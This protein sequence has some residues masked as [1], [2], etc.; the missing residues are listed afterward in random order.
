M[1]S[2]YLRYDGNALV[3]PG[4]MCDE[5]GEIATHLGKKLEGSLDANGYLTSKIIIGSGEQ[6][7]LR[8]HRIIMST[9]D[10]DGYLP[11]LEIS[12]KNGVK[13]D[14]RLENLEWCTGK[15]NIAHAIKIGLIRTMD[16]EKQALLLAKKDSI[17][18]RRQ[19]VSEI[20]LLANEL[21]SS[22]MGTMQIAKRIGMSANFVKNRAPNPNKGDRPR[23]YSDEELAL[24]VKLRESGSTFP[25]I[26]KKLGTKNFE[27]MSHQYRRAKGALP[28]EGKY[29]KYHKP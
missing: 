21:R 23:R 3:L 15:E 27:G 11:G 7:S 29:G 10:P 26:A 6:K 18:E 24:I 12:H 13:K 1:N 4:V 5:S 9:L 17:A 28:V 22:G 19:R 25:E 2:I 8:H 20:A 16:E 14:N